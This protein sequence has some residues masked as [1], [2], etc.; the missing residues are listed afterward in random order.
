MNKNLALSINKKGDL[1]DHLF[2]FNIQGLNSPQLAAES[3]SRA[4]PGVHM[5]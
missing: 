1:M 5:F 4:C 3:G 2:L